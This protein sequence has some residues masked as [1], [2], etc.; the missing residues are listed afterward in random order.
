MLRVMSPCG[1]GS[2]SPVLWMASFMEASEDGCLA[3][4]WG[5]V[6]CCKCC[7]E[8]GLLCLW[9]RMSSKVMCEGL[10]MVR[11]VGIQGRATIILFLGPF[12]RLVWR[13]PICSPN[14]ASQTRAEGT[15]ILSLS[16]FT[17]L[18]PLQALP[19]GL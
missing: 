16:L 17:S 11:E 14:S 6:L 15:S 18:I 7:G 5:L 9:G 12:Q 19:H 4:A 2:R 1:R 10:S 3:W 8:T 13:P